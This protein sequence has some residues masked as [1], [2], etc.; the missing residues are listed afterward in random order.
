[1]G[2]KTMM[3]VERGVSLAEGYLWRAF[4]KKKKACGELSLSD[5]CCLWRA[6][7]GEQRIQSRM[8]VVHRKKTRSVHFCS[9]SRS[10]EAALIL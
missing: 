5:T 6:I 10:A 3:G 9:M 1:M 4:P 7:T 2:T 8:G